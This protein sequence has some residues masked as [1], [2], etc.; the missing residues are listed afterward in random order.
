[1]MKLSHKTKKVDSYIGSLSTFKGD[2]TT[3]ASLIIEGC[4]EGNII[5]EGEVTLGKNA[6][7]SGDIT[8]HCITVAGTVKGNIHAQEY[9][10]ISV[11][12]L[13]EGDIHTKSFIADEGSVF[14]G[15]CIMGN[16]TSES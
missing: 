13:V 9:V 1:M 7:V 2:I 15:R 3:N 14:N 10:K 8:A 16:A 4:V 6:S 12:S 11:G 5:S